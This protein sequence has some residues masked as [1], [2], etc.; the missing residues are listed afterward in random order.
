ML[1]GDR[2]TAILIDIRVFESIGRFRS[3]SSTQD[4][5]RCELFNSTP[6]G[7]GNAFYR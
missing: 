5:T 6:K 2:R 1:R 4:A 7:S 3:V